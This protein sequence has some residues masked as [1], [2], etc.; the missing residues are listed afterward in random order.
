LGVDYEAEAEEVGNNFGAVEDD[1]V[2]VEVEPELIH[3]REGGEVEDG[4]EE[5]QEGE[6]DCDPSEGGIPEQIDVSK[7]TL[8]GV[9]HLLLVVLFH[10]LEVGLAEQVALFEYMLG[11]ID[12]GDF[13]ETFPDLSHRVKFD[14]HL[15]GLL[16][17]NEAHY[18]AEQEGEDQE[19]QKHDLPV[20]KDVEG[21]G[22]EA[23]S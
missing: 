6:A 21:N 3:N 22:R 4:A 9:L 20:L 12:D 13:S 8:M 16:K 5:E 15:R 14:E 7:G 11:S 2:E 18:G 23:S 17:I 1:A 19:Q 10:L